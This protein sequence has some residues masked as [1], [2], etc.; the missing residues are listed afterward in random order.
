METNI[1]KLNGNIERFN[2]TPDL[3]RKLHQHQKIN[4]K[5]EAEDLSF[6]F[7]KQFKAFLDKHNLEPT[8]FNLN[9]LNKLEGVILTDK[10]VEGLE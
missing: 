4:K 10:Q 9:C 6:R 2:L 7:D 5:G 1:L 8:I 3:N